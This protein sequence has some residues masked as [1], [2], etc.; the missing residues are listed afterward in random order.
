MQYSV[1]SL[2]FCVLYSVQFLATLCL[3]NGNCQSFTPKFLYRRSLHLLFQSYLL[4]CRF[5][6]KFDAIAFLQ[7]AIIAQFPSAS[8]FSVTMALTKSG[9]CSVFS[10]TLPPVECSC[11]WHPQ[12]PPLF[13][14]SVRVCDNRAM[15]NSS[16]SPSACKWLLGTRWSTTQTICPKVYKCMWFWRS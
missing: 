9:K 7:P 10:L 2:G 13:I 15:T 5:P 14:L 8:C 6:G 3:L 12:S 16:T 4:S 1:S 11:K